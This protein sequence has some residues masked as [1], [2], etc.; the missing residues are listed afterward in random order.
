[1]TSLLCIL[2]GALASAPL[3]MAVTFWIS[4]RVWRNARRMAARAKGHDNLV[5]LAHL[6]GG[7]AHE[8]KNPLSTINMNLKLLSE[9]LGRYHDEEH[10]RFQRRIGAIQQESQ[11]LREILDDFLHYAGKHELHPQRV[12]LRQVVTELADFFAAQASVA[13]IVL[14]TSA[15]EHPVLADID[16]NLIKQALLNLMLNAAQAMTHGGELLIRVGADRARA[17]IEV[18][19]TGPGIG[20]EDIDRIFQVYYSTKKGGSGLGLPTARRIVHEHGGTLQ[21]QSELG[22][23][24]RFVIGLPLPTPAPAPAIGA[25]EGKRA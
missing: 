14:R 10:A 4:R 17:V 15:P 20:P 13:H 1:M 23:G 21:V 9:D 25:R 11:R 2:L 24:T 6:A 16:I 22:K 3:W 7:L 19:D 18:I 12:D 5:E 8:I